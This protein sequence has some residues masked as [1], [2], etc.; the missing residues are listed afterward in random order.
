[1]TQ[2]FKKLIEIALDKVFYKDYA[3]AIDDYNKAIEL[4][5]NYAIAYYNR[6]GAKYDL[7]DY[8]GAIEDYNKAIE[9]DQKC[10]HFYYFRAKSKKE[11][12]DIKGHD[13]DMKKYEKLQKKYI[14]NN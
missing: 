2:E 13:K 4:N 10:K 6:G 9:L 3:G 14:F 5:P 1:M 11:I 12:G 7:K 8:A